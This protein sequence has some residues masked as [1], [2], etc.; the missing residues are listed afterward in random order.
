MKVAA[1]FPVK[2]FSFLAYFILLVHGLLLFV[3]IL[4]LEFIW[5]HIVLLISLFF[6]VYFSFRHYQNITAA[7]DDLCW[8]GENWLIHLDQQQKRV[9]Y[10][11]L[12]SDSWISGYFCLLHLSD[13]NKHFYWLFSRYG[14]GNRMYSELIYL[15]RQYLKINR[16]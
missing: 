11:K 13:D 5:Q 9:A 16:T 2:A 4:G 15:A 7:P 12:E 6:S 14:L 10:L 3:G 8:N 1:R